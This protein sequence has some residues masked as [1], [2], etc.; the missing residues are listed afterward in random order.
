MRKCSLNRSKSICLPGTTHVV[1]QE[2]SRII[3]GCR[4]H[5]LTMAFTFQSS[6]TC[7]YFEVKYSA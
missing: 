2:Q 3:K 5:A 6:K 7:I 4:D 1:S